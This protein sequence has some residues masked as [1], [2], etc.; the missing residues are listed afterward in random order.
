MGTYIMVGPCCE[1]NVDVRGL[2]EK[3]IEEVVAG[4]SEFI[5]TAAY[6][7][8][9]RDGYLQFTPKEELFLDGFKELVE[10]QYEIW[11]VKN[12]PENDTEAVLS[13]LSEIKKMDELIDLADGKKNKLL[14]Y[15][16]QK[17]EDM[18]YVRYGKWRESRNAWV[19]IIILYSVGKAY[20]ECY[21]DFFAGM[22]KLIKLDCPVP[23]SRFIKAVLLTG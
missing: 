3:T 8:V 1:F 5:D 10:R 13:K 20:L 7:Y 12:E 9:V 21:N 16:Y 19:S 18:W 15:N 4:S 14:S 11:G 2:D 17:T 6:N 23:A 22:E